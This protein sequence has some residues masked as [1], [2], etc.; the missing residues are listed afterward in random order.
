[1][2]KVCKK[3][4]AEKDISCFSKQ[5]TNIDGYKN[6]C[7]ICINEHG[8]KYREQNIKAEIAR[9]NLYYELHKTERKEYFDLHKDSKREYA[10]RYRK[11]NAEIIKE[12]RKASYLKN[13]DKKREQ[14]YR[15]YLKRIDNDPLFKLKKQIQSVVRSSIRSKG[16][17]KQDRTLSILGCTVNEFKLHIES[18]FE[19]WMNWDNYGLFNGQPQYGWDIDHIQRTSSATTEEELI[20]LNHYTNLQPLCSYINRNV[21]R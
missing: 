6:V 18:L 17:I 7:K 5:A 21:K 8:R 1:M 11:D 19:P 20:Q 15:S 9:S 10:A 14:N 12:R 16:Y 2:R 3:C 13:K 4:G